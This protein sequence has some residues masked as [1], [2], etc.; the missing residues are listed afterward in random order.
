MIR[1]PVTCCHPDPGS[2]KFNVDGSAK[3]N[4]GPAGCGGVL[5]DSSGAIFA[6]FSGPLGIQVP[7]AADLLAIRTDLEV[8]LN[9]K[10]KSFSVLIDFLV[11][12]IRVVCFNNIFR[13][14]NMIADHLAK[15]GVSR[16]DMFMAWW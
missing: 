15:A 1:S 14:A 13:E 9:L 11:S 2:V 16:E 4:P 7:T 8:F 10:F 3:G 5:R 12:L 6:M